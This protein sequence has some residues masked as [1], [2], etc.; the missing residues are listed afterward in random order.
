MPALDV[1]Q[2]YEYAEVI[3]DAGLQNLD[4]HLTAGLNAEHRKFVRSAS[5]NLKVNILKHL[6]AREVIA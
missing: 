1:A 3:A 5:K 4:L 2:M 6:N